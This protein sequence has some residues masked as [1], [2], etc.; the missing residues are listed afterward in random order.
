MK[1]PYPLRS[2]HVQLC[3]ATSTWFTEIKT[4]FTEVSHPFYNCILSPYSRKSKYHSYRA[5]FKHLHVFKMAPKAK[6]TRPIEFNTSYLEKYTRKY[7][8]WSLFFIKLQVFSLQLY[9][10]ETPVKVFFCEFYKIF[11]TRF[12]KNNS[13]GLLREEHC[14]A[15]NYMLKVCNRSTRTR[16]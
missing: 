16:C 12:F 10:K 2:L 14:P 6:S 11:K 5:P 15:G 7:L 9:Q 1:W 8:Q 3:I 4:K 13:R